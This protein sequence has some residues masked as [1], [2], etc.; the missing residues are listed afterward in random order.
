MR[1][2]PAVFLAVVLT[3]SVSLAETPSSDS[4]MAAAKTKAALEQKA[5][6]VHFGASWCGWCR[7]LDAYLDRPDVKPVFEKYFVPVKLDMGEQPPKKELENAGADELAK[8]LGGP[9]FPFHAFLDAE[10]KLIINSN[11][12]PAGN[13]GYPAQPDEIDWFLQM[14]KKAAPKITDSD[15]K[16]LEAPLRTESSSAH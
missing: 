10:G 4:L 9:G 2:F 16:A 1:A 6:F 7:K 11:H 8:K 14:V 15:L 13:I 12:E 3:T 5:I